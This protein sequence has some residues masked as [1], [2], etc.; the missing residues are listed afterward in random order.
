ISDWLLKTNIYTDSEVN[1]RGF[2]PYSYFALIFKPSARFFQTYIL[3]KGYREGKE[4]FIYAVL[5]AIYKFITLIKQEEKSNEN[6][7]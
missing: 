7:L 4:G 3:K 1:R 2:G 6:S 5:N